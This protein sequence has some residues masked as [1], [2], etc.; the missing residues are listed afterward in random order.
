MT[1]LI[2]ALAAV[3]AVLFCGFLA[4]KAW[5]GPKVE[6]EK[7]EQQKNRQEFFKRRVATIR[8]RIAINKKPPTN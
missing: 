2:I 1:T 8:D 4:V 3:A 7:T 5:N 6:A